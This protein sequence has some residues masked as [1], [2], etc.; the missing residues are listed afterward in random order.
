[1]Y[2]CMH[3]CMYVCM[4]GCMYVCMHACMHVCMYIYIYIY[5]DQY[6]TIAMYTSP[7]ES[8][9]HNQDPLYL[10]LVELDGL[11][12]GLHQLLGIPGVLRHG[13]PSLGHG[14]PWVSLGSNSWHW[15]YTQ[16]WNEWCRISMVIS[17]SLLYGIIT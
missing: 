12:R 10:S 2:V 13:W 16:H 6:H 11:H 5:M 17:Y 9:F 14:W 7:T 1:M 3:G 15:G 4:H 8:L